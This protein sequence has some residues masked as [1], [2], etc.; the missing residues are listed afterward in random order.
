M[1]KEFYVRLFSNSSTEIYPANTLANFTTVLDSPI[2]LD[3][4]DNYHV[5]ISELHINNFE[6]DDHIAHKSNDLIVFDKISSDAV[7]KKFGFKT[8]VEYLVSKSTAHNLYNKQ[9]FIKY[10]NKN[11]RWNPFTFVM[12]FSEDQT[13]LLNTEN[14]FKVTLDLTEFLQKGE[15]KDLFFRYGNKATKSKFEQC[16]IMF[17]AKRSYNLRQCFFLILSRIFF[18]LNSGYDEDDDANI[19]RLHREAKS[20]EKYNEKSK[21]YADNMNIFMRRVITNFVKRSVA[22]SVVQLQ[23]T[24]A[25]EHP[26]H[27]FIYLDIVVESLVGDKRMKCVRIVP[28]K[29]KENN[30]HWIFSH[31]QFH[32]IEKLR[33]KEISV[34]M[35]DQNGLPIHFR[36]S[37]VPNYVCLNFRGE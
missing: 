34:S 35:L 21:L 33:F 16:E 31:P 4:R 20:Y 30:Q 3:E 1:V 9:Y 7:H 8:L 6:Y 24:N 37:F 11:I 32:K 18:V 22:Y 10:L 2:N 5:G 28:L 27:I 14:I 29:E 36:N 26:S 19:E 25:L 12:S 13:F 17:A 23:R 15:S